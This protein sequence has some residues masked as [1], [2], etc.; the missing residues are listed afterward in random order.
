MSN[1]DPTLIPTHSELSDEKIE[2]SLRGE[3]SNPVFEV[4]KKYIDVI[5]T[6]DPASTDRRDALVTELILSS[7]YTLDVLTLIAIWAEGLED[8]ARSGMSRGFSIPLIAVHT[9]FDP[10]NEESVAVVYDYIKTG[11]IGESA[12]SDEHYKRYIE[13]ARSRLGRVFRGLDELSVYIHG[14]P[15]AMTTV[16]QLAKSDVPD[17]K[18]R[19]EELLKRGEEK[20]NPVFSSVAENVTNASMRLGML[21]Q[22]YGD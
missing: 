21:L 11:T 13:G 4:A 8:P 17:D 15:D 12:M 18:K 9:L 6:H 14:V 1:V 16:A 22:R 19:L 3:S 10:T 2:A 5:R 7:P 20:G